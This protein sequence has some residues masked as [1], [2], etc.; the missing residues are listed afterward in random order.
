M[1]IGASADRFLTL[2]EEQTLSAWSVYGHLRFIEP[3]QAKWLELL[4]TELPTEKRTRSEIQKRFEAQFG[5]GGYR[6]PNLGDDL[7]EDL[8]RYWLRCELGQ[9][10]P[11]FSW[12]REIESFDADDQSFADWFREAKAK[13]P[14]RM[15]IAEAATRISD[16]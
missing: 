16:S 4:L 9:P 8:V 7:S 14:K 2:Q 6:L 1:A 10:K 15:S 11:K 3:I 13:M 5:F 12:G